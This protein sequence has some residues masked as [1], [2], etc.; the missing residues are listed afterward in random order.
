MSKGALKVKT[1]DGFRVVGSGLV[2]NTE[3][4]I[5]VSSFN[6][7][8][9]TV[10]PQKGDYSA[11]M[12]AFSDGQTFQ[13]K[14]DSGELKG[15]GVPGDAG[16]GI[17]SVQQTTTSNA[18]GGTNVIT[19]TK[20]DGTTSTFTV[21]NGNKGSKGDKGDTGE[22]GAKGDKGDK[23]D[24]GAAGATPKK[25]TDYFTAADVAQIVADVV[26]QM[27]AANTDYT[28][29]RARGIVLAQDNAVSVPDG[30]LCG[31]YTIS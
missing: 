9:G 23:G 31:V 29:C 10:V 6:A 7:R 17:Q 8:T 24:T 25:G 15:E 27:G 30:C 22:T 3:S 14:Y 2:E 28:T 26:A 5:G 18:D 13:Q 21:K 11:D 19:V 12:I 20:T 1:P 4:V 16:V